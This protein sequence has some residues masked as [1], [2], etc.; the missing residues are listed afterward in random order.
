M[1]ESRDGK[2]PR[3][4]KT[5]L[6]GLGVLFLL[7]LMVRLHHL[8]HESLFFDEIRQVSYYPHSIERI[9]LDAA[10]QQ[11][12][13]L[14]YWT[15]HVAGFIS[16]SDF[17][18]RVPA[19]I[20]GSASVILLVLLLLQ[21]TN[22]PT[23]FF[24]GLVAALLP[25][26]I[27]YSQMARPYAIAI[28]FTL[29]TIFALDRT[30]RKNATPLKHGA[31]LFLCAAGY[32]LSRSYTPLLVIVT[33]LAVLMI[34]FLYLW[35]GDA[36]QKSDERK[37]IFSACLALGAALLVCL[38][39]LKQII[40]MG[41]RFAPGTT[42]PVTAILAAGF[43]RFSLRPLW[44][45]YLT[46]AEPV[47]LIL[48]PLVLISPLL[49][50]MT[51]WRRNFLFFTVCLLLPVAAMLDC[52]I[53]PA[54]S[55]WVFRPAYPLYLLPLCLL[56]GAVVFS[57]LWKRAN[58]PAASGYWLRGI[59]VFTAIAA[60]LWTVHSAI[61]FKNTPKHE[62]WRG[63]TRYLAGSAGPGQLLIF[64][65]V[66]PYGNWEPGSFGFP[67][68]YQGKSVIFPLSMIPQAAGVMT[69]AKL[70]PIAVLFVY[71]DIKLT[72]DSPYPVMPSFTDYKIDI[73][74]VSRDP[75]LTTQAFTSFLTVRLKSPTGN[76]AVD[77]LTLFR[78]ILGRLPDDSST[79]DIRLAI[80]SLAK[81]LGDDKLAEDNLT[82]AVKLAPPGHK[83]A[84][85]RIADAVRSGH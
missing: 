78:L 60:L 17:A 15:G 48:L 33:I 21:L 27:Y 35:R 19:A 69:K 53:F 43:S 34:R 72:P 20:F 7:T 28:F 64:D 54:M 14:D 3:S 58:I 63:L 25:F 66:T 81:A 68:Y 16:G 73:T 75:R 57:E 2:R 24:T 13:P 22:P 26:N 11:Q 4:N 31:L 47:G 71:R 62:D 40:K 59:L 50:L 46:Q 67:R 32:L 84:V 85:A 45:A 44:E 82:L 56:L 12:P 30:V 77:T 10:S 49:L 80:A 6:W 38:P 65:A 52:F 74:P 39:L 29:M 36:L 51:R 1:G 9:V 55:G 76:S 37:G 83:A 42:K 8:D 61:V 70:E 5:V 23:A 41:E 18:V 79:V